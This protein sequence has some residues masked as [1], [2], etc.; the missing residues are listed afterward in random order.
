M[1]GQDVM[2]LESPTVHT[3]SGSRAFCPGATLAP[4]GKA[5]PGHRESEAATSYRQ[6][7]RIT[8]A[9]AAPSASTCSTSPATWLASIK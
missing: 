4:V 5:E 3:L 2:T 6:F 9:H 7:G 1:A 8:S